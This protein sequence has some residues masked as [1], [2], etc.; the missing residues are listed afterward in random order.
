MLKLSTP[1]LMAIAGLEHLV[2]AILA[3]DDGARQRLW[4]ALEPRLDAMLRRRTFFG[5]LAASQDHRR[6][7]IVE[8]MARLAEGDHARLRRFAA[9]RR[10]NPDLPLLGWLAVVVRRVAIDYMRAQPE[11]VDRR[12]EAEASAP[13]GWRE[14]GTLP[15]ERG[16]PAAEGPSATGKAAA[17]R[18]LELATE[19]LS[20][21]QQVALAGWLAG[22]SFREIAQ[23]HAFATARD[24]E[25][26]V[27]SSLERIR[28]HVRREEP[29]RE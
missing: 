11:Y 19:L 18:L 8:V 20:R 9:A 4:R 10:E 12:K 3:G 2:D 6:N 13:G 17:H 7:V 15:S 25:R 28:R 22:Q 5:P 26:A 24:A 14:V 1:T 23:A 16:I 27:R 21:E 29:D